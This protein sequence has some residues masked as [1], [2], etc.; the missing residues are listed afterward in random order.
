MALPTGFE[1]EANIFSDLRKNH[2]LSLRNFKTLLSNMGSYRIGL[3]DDVNKQLLIIIAFET[4]K[5]IDNKKYNKLKNF[6]KNRGI[7][8]VNNHDH[9]IVFDLAKTVKSSTTTVDE[10]NR[11]FKDMLEN[12]YC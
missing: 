10:I 7:L 11:I 9:K 5:I 1:S 6:V 4:L 12:Q 2:G 8:D 3:F